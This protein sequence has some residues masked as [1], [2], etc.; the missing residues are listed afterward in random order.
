VHPATDTGASSLGLEPAG[1]CWK[2]RPDRIK[3]IAQVAFSALSVATGQIRFQSG[4][5]R[6]GDEKSG[7][8][9]YAR[10]QNELQSTL[11]ASYQ[12][13][14]KGSPGSLGADVGPVHPGGQPGNAPP[15][16]QGNDDHQGQD[17]DGDHPILTS[18]Q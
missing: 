10:Y 12:R 6:I 5:C 13:C 14:V 15:H 3:D 18:A 4:V 1:T 2:H 7:R 17:L 11:G 8:R 16:D 9:I